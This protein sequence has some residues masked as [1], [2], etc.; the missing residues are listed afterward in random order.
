MLKRNTV[1]VLGAGASRQAG[2][3][4]AGGE[5]RLMGRVIKLL[6]LPKL[7]EIAGKVFGEP[8]T[9][10]VESAKDFHKRLAGSSQPS[11]DEFLRLTP[12]HSLAAL[13]KLCMASALGQTES[14][15]NLEDRHL[16]AAG[17]WYPLLWQLLCDGTNRLEDF[18]RNKVSIITFNYER[19]VEQFL[20]SR[21]ENNYATSFAEAS[22]TLRNTFRF[23]HVYGQ[24]GEF[25]GAKAIP[26]GSLRTSSREQDVNWLRVSADQ[27]YIPHEGETEDRGN[28]ACKL[29]S[30]AETLIFLGFNFQ[31]TNVDKIG[32]LRIPA[33]YWRTQHVYV[34][35]KGMTKL[36]YDEVNQL[37][38][39]PVMKGRLCIGDR[40][41]D[42]RTFLSDNFVG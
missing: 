41:L 19:S 5:D 24:L 7:P 11:A 3:P 21:I 10:F 13:G 29:I 8:P 35:T 42:A 16:N 32:L 33:P 27:I 17:S 1:F 18:R 36:R 9:Y 39:K 28:E 23:V 4:L 40:G 34:C 2:F 6:A 25:F 30:E 31:G 26:Y 14:V 38:S 22:E 37:L 15:E 12:N 20:T